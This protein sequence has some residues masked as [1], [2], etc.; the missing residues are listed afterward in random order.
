[1]SDKRKL[2]KQVSFSHSNSVL[3][4][5]KTENSSGDEELED[6]SSLKDASLNL[7]KA[8]TLSSALKKPQNSSI[9]L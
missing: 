5:T 9:G 7:R 1:M 3:E 8:Y 4:F 6:N 2:K